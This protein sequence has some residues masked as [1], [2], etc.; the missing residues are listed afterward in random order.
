[1]DDLQREMDINNDIQKRAVDKLVEYYRSTKNPIVS[2]DI[3]ELYECIL[4]NTDTADLSIRS[5]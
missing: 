1:M 5:K 2:E 4:K 3:F